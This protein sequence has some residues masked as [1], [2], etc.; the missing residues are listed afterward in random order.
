MS[1]H[2]DRLSI[3][4][5]PDPATG[6]RRLTVSAER[7]D[8]DAPLGLEV[9]AAATMLVTEEAWDAAAGREFLGDSDADN[10]RAKTLAER[11]VLH[12]DGAA[13][14]R[15]LTAEHLECARGD[16]DLNAFVE[17]KVREARW[18]V[19]EHVDTDSTNWFCVASG[20]ECLREAIRDVELGDLQQIMELNALP[21]D[22]F[23]PT[24]HPVRITDESHV[25]Q[26]RST[27]D[28]IVL[29]SL[30]IAHGRGPGHDEAGGRIPVAGGVIAF[31]SCSATIVVEHCDH[32]GHEAAGFTCSTRPITELG[33]RDTGEACPCEHVPTDPPEKM[34]DGRA[35]WRCTR[36]DVRSTVMDCRPITARAIVRM[37]YTPFVPPH[38][39]ADDRA[40]GCAMHGSRGPSEDGRDLLRVRGKD[41]RRYLCCSLLCWHELDVFLE[42][43]GREGAHAPTVLHVR[44]LR[45][46]FNKRFQVA[47][48]IRE[49]ELAEGGERPRLGRRVAELRAHDL[50]VAGSGKAADIVALGLLRIRGPGTLGA[51]LADEWLDALDRAAF[52]VVDD[53]RPPSP[54]R[55]ARAP[56]ADG[57][58]VRVAFPYED[59]PDRI[60]I[61][62]AESE[63][64]GTSDG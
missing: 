56:T 30:E 9:V 33:Q 3:I 5:A 55:W 11:L 18:S 17:A 19:G 6:G 53:P 4:V 50:T 22:A 23:E 31:C 38:F 48:V 44:A 28:K 49:I 62:G 36:C 7:E 26:R 35:L 24:K 51:Y 37:A 1:D 43:L 39:G 16:L 52:D 59:P 64:D 63:P 47:V 46:T 57:N 61:G 60:V 42:Q 40:R 45:S 8:D 41:G 34:A 12:G 25:V 54:R 29:R 21:D 15:A 58:V 10:L 20:G 27:R 32:V 13:V 2:A 14:R